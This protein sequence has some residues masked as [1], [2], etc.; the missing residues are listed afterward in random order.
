MKGATMSTQD[1]GTP[2][3]QTVEKLATQE[4]KLDRTALIG[5]FGTA[6]APKA[7]I[8]LPRGQTRTVTVGDRI[9]GATVGAIGEDRL[10]L[11]RGS[12]QEVMQMPRG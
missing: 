6:S 8:R 3:P 4:V 7:L 12:R 5:I 10:V 9:A 11:V 2:T 1:A